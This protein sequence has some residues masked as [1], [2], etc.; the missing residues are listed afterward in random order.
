MYILEI[1]DRRTVCF[2]LISQ[3]LPQNVMRARSRLPG[4][5]SIA[6]CVVDVSGGDLEQ[7]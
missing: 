6:F 5:A 4:L 7:L 2:T 1:V 3:N